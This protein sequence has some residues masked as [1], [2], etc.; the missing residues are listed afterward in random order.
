MQD[1]NTRTSP[2]PKLAL[3][4]TETAQALGVRAVTIERLPKD[5]PLVQMPRSALLGG[6]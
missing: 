5:G 1:E 6:A 3:T 2:V 4:R